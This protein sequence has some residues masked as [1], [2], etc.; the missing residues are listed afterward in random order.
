VQRKPDGATGGHGAL[1]ASTSGASAGLYVHLPFCPYVCPY[2]DF[3]KWKHDGVRAER[4]LRALRAEAAHAPA[5][6][7]ATMFFGGG[8][9]NTYAPDDVAAL[10]TELVARFGIPSG[11]EVSIEVNPDLALCDGFSAYRAAGITRL[12]IGVQSF[13]PA[14]LH[15]LGRQ[16]TPDDVALVVRRARTAGFSNVSLDLMF[17]TPHQTL[18]SWRT[19]LERAVA[20]GADHISTYGLTVEAGTPYERWFGREPSAFGDQDAQ[21][22]LYG[23][24]IDLLTSAGYEQYEIS[25]FARPGYRCAHNANYWANG[26]YLG[27]GVGAASYLGGERR[28]TTRDLTA[29]ES[30]ALAGTPIAAQRE[31]LEGAAMVGEA[32]MLALRTNEGVELQSFAERY[33]VDF[34]EMYR[35]VLEELSAAGLVRTSPTHIALTRRGRFLANDACGAFVVPA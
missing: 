19:S 23:L 7:C 33:H 30:A 9:P 11:A 4:Y 22:D 28:T 20:L 10:A 14:E 34:V 8:T 26:E 15:A 35:P 25:N 29:Y 3:A 21:A 31:R 24:A 1:R 12:S 27:L 17:G 32:A 16:H 2:C 18:A 5:L 13:V 6:R